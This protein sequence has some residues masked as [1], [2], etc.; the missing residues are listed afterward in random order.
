MEI[1]VF[2]FRDFLLSILWSSGRKYVLFENIIHPCEG[3][4]DYIAYTLNRFSPSKPSTGKSA[5][6]KYN[7]EAEDQNCTDP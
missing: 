5:S 2:N 6:V 1:P 4:H 3:D 7:K